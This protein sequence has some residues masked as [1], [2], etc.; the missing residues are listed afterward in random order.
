MKKHRHKQ[1]NISDEILHM[2]LFLHEHFSPKIKTEKL[3]KLKKKK[4]HEMRAVGGPG[5]L[6]PILSRH[7]SSVGALIFST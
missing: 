7:L 5:K 1:L 2:L 4:R 6:I 3:F